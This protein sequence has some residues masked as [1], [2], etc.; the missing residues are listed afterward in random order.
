MLVM[1]DRAFARRLGV[2]RFPP[3]VSGPAQGLDPAAPFEAHLTI[4]AAC[5]VACQGCYID[6]GRDRSTTLSHG[7][8]FAILERLAGM[9]VYHLALGGGEDTDWEWLIEL[10][11]R[12]RRLGMTPNL[13]TAG[14]ELTPRLARRLEVFERVHVSLDGVGATYA[15]MRGHDGFARAR[16]G[17]EILRAY[18]DRVGVNCVVGRRNAYELPALFALLDELGVRELE[19]LRFKPV[20]RGAARYEQLGLSAAH[21]AGLV[22]RILGLA[23]RHRV[24]VRLDCSFTPLVC[25]SGVSPARLTR[26]GV[27]GCVAGSWLLSVGPDGQVSGCSYDHQGVSD[28]RQLGQAGVMQKFQSWTSRAPEPCAG[29][30]WLSICR[31]GCHVVARHVTGRFDAPDPG[32]PFVSGVSF[33]KA[34]GQSRSGSRSSPSSA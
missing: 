24:R 8:W 17:L 2:R 27:A 3:P 21:S 1:V 7:D 20:G 25:A 31:G 30:R 18:H 32:C 19:L 22:G 16:M 11:R 5:S 14:W 13:T 34:S 9:G 28:W 15:A 12:A 6:A 10:A 29:C 23:L 33:G 4:S 26:L